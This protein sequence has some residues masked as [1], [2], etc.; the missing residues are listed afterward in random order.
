MPMSLRLRAE[1]VLLVLLVGAP[2]LAGAQPTP[3]NLKYRS[4]QT[5]QPIY[6]GWSRNP[7]GGFTMHFGYFNRN[8]VEEVHV[9]VGPDNHFE[10]GDLD[11]GQPTF[12]YPRAH[13]RVFSIDVP[14]D[15][16]D[17]RLVWNLTVQGE[18]LRAIGWLEPTWQTG[19]RSAGGRRLNAEA[20][21]N[22]APAIAIEAP[23]DVTLPGRPTLIARVTDDGLPVVREIDPASRVAGSNDPPTLRRDPDEPEPPH[24]VPSVPNRRGAGL[25]GPRVRGLRV[26]WIVWRGPVGVSFEPSS[27]VAVEDGQAAVT[28]TF[29]EPGDYVLRATANDNLLAT[30]HDVS[31]T[32]R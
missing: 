30:E 1:V 9:P 7:D 25:Q 26:S 19:A 4:G 17:R 12:F 8:F 16:G 14:A 20:A 23:A 13:R 2:S 31:I 6:E 32:V 11:S 24:N 10:P 18:T 27:T 21:R 15:F 3:Y 28:A 29:A 5:V 22:T